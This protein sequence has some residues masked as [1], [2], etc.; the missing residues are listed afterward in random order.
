MCHPNPETLTFIHTRIEAD[1]G[2]RHDAPRLCCRLSDG[3]LGEEALL[4]EE[5]EDAERLL[6]QIDTALV[7]V[8]RNGL[9]R[10]PEI[11]WCQT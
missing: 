6:D 8:E 2:S 1:L 11:M 7:V 10:D 9:P 3:Y 5:R 4:V